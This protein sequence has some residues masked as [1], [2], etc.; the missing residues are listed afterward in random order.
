MYLSFLIIPP[1]AIP[2]VSQGS[3]L[4]GR[5]YGKLVWGFC[6]ICFPPPHPH[7]H[8]HIIL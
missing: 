8:P 4:G 2:G 3:L 5:K 6:L 1:L 7:P